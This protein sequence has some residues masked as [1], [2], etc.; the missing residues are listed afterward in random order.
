MHQR[1]IDSW[2]HDHT[3][4]TDAHRHG[5][6]RTRW[7]VALTA[8]MMVLE[9]AAGIAF[10][11]MAL[12][13]DGWHMATHAAALGVAAFA[14]AYTR[15]HASD[16]RY[17]FGTG[18]VGALAGFASAVGLA[19]VALVVFAES[20]ARLTAPVAIRYDEAIAVACLGLLVNIASAVLLRDHE[21]G[22]HEPAEHHHDHN[23]RGAY[24]HVLADAL[25]S[26]LAIAALVA[27]KALGWTWMDP[28]TGLVGSL[29]IARWSF[30]LLRDTSGVL[31]DAEVSD[32]R[33]RAIQH[34]IESD[35]DNRVADLHLW[36]V[37]P[38]HLAAIVSVVTHEPRD[39]AHY[40]R[41]LEGERDL[42]HVTIEVQACR[43]DG[44]LA[45]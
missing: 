45:A 43:G 38:Q 13:A 2:Q 10:G 31:L 19:V 17:S 39:P 44:C 12:L 36:R 4:G 6:R 25:T 16:R 32:E 20:A 37:G 24:L 14:Y 34:A 9:I 3:F 23:L 1:T 33:S 15:R 30:G 41:L 7:V 29:V 27:G 5:E 35:A 11:S 26:V 21:H 28:V 40:K 22:A 42:V 18:K 8:G